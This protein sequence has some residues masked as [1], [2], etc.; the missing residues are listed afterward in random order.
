MKWDTR[1]Q[2]L[3]DAGLLV[4]S[5]SLGMTG[6]NPLEINLKRFSPDGVVYDIVYAPLQTALLQQAADRGCRTVDGLGMLLHQARPAFAAWFGVE[7][8][9]TDALRAAIVQ[10]LAQ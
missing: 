9:V 1:N 5:T 7:P 10:D 2:A 8:K 3:T 6:E 4:N